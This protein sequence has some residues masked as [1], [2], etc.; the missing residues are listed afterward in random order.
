MTATA[1][2]ADTT[3]KRQRSLDACERRDV[4]WIGGSVPPPLRAALLA[5]HE[6]IRISPDAAQVNETAPYACA[7]IIESRADMKDLEWAMPALDAAIDHG[8]RVILS[9]PAM[10]PDGDELD[11][12][13]RENCFRLRQSLGTRA[14]L[15][16]YNDWH[17]YAD[18]IGYHAPSAGCNYALQIT[19]DLPHEAGAQIL[20]RR[21]FHDFQGIALEQLPGG[22]SGAAV[23]IVRPSSADR[24]KRATPFLVKWNSLTKVSEEKSNVTQYA[25]GRVSF[26]LTPPLHE[27]RCVEGVATGLLV[28]DFIERAISFDE[29]IRSYPA[30]Q[31]IGS[32]FDHTLAGCLGPATDAVASL[33]EPFERYNI[34]RWSDLNDVA[35]VAAKED[36]DIPSVNALRKRLASIGPVPHRSATVHGDMHR[37]NLL[38]AA[39]SS[40]V[41][42]IDFGKIMYNMPAVSDAACLE[43]SLALPSLVG[44][45]RLARTAPRADIDWLR[46][47]YA[48]PL[49]PHSVPARDDRERWLPAAL[50]ALR[51]AARQHDPSPIAYGVAV[52]SYMLRYASYSSNGT[53][54]DRAIAYALAAR[55]ASAAASSVA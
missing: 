55:L 54:D 23:W 20:I 24:A 12:K 17:R 52:L 28:F 6:L 16:L 49:D 34:L 36:A 22:H 15:T 1:T 39:G 32:L 43:V 48:F 19:G 25:R 45:A 5:A 33:I 35:D 8:V 42:L 38:I 50:R 9:T 44:R 26:R 14:V 7:L 53:L 2:T 27:A 21:A 13:A 3:S 10:S 41:L 47:A 18:N 30:G 40:D 46:Q 37:D 31:L 51:A 29:A 4:L 11:I